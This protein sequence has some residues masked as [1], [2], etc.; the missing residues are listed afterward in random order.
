MSSTAGDFRSLTPIVLQEALAAAGTAVLEP[1]HQFRLELP[2]DLLGPHPADPDPA[3][4]GPTGA[5]HLRG[6]GRGGG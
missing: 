6:A 1:V 5:Q 4:C 2:A 3:G